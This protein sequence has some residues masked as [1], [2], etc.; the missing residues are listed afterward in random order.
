MTEMHSILE[1]EEGSSEMELDNAYKG[2]RQ[3]Y[4]M[5]IKS[6]SAKSRIRL[7]ENKLAK[8]DTAYKEYVGKASIPELKEKQKVC[9]AMKQMRSRG[10][11]REV[12]GYPPPTPT[13]NEDSIQLSL[14]MENLLMK[15]PEG[16]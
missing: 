10:K 4:L 7:L 2:K 5:E 12:K 11:Y 9:S 15:R 8:L 14:Q 1:I 13:L 6:T 3:R 16:R